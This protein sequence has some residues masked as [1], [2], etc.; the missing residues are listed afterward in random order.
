MPRFRRPRVACH[1]AESAPG[2]DRRYLPRYLPA[3]RRARVGWW[4]EG[5]VRAVA[6]RIVD[7]GIGGAAVELAKLPPPG[8]HVSLRLRSRRLPT[9]SIGAEVIHVAA[10]PAGTFLV[11][12]A[13]DM[14]CPPALFE[15]ATLGFDALEALLN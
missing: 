10:R 8:Q 12:L 11:R 9:G 1:R 3:V 5:V 15:A 13:F 2:G 7:I 6:A 14:P 4:E